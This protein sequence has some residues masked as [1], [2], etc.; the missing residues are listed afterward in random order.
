MVERRSKPRIECDYPAIVR[1]S[2][3]GTVRF[4]ES[5]TLCNFS[6]S[7]LYLRAKHH[8]EQGVKLL[9]VVRF[10][11]GAPDKVTAPILAILGVVA[12][13]ESRLDDTCGLG[14]KL[15]RYRFL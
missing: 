2:S 10:S 14:V 8:I 15:L 5:A 12:R 9:V 13:T 1:G 3:P 7:G 6:A 4:E 11:N